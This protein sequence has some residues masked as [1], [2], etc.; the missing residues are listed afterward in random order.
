MK[1]LLV[2][3]HPRATSLTQAAARAFADAATAKGHQMEWADLAAEHF[4]TS[5]GPADEPD[6]GDPRK[7]YLFDPGL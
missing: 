7:T 4:D 3:A 5:L 1:I 2:I 6:W